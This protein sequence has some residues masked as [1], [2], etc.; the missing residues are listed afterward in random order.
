[1]ARIPGRTIDGAP[2]AVRPLLEE[3]L[4]FS[5]NGQLLNMHAQMARAP[6]VLEGYVA[7]RKAA[8]R[9]ATLDAAMRSAIMLTAASAAGSPYAVALLSTLAL[10]SGWRPDQVQS[11]LEGKDPGDEKTNALIGVAREAAANRGRVTEPAWAR[12]AGLG[13]SSEQLAEAFASLGLAVFTA[14]FLNY[15]ET[16]LDIPAP[17]VAGGA[18]T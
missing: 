10:R 8:G 11:L 15:A 9:K 3:M 12:A 1:M 13:W 16:E 7:L 6:A 14:Y 2:P 4:Q 5:P 17:P 18:R